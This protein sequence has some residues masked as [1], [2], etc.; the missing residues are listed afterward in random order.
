MLTA[1]V[2]FLFLLATIIEL[3]TVLKNAEKKVKIIH[4]SMMLI[5]FCVLMLYSLDITVPSPSGVI[6]S[7]IEAVFKLKG[8]S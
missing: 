5:S 8:S 6:V 7:V 2:L 3:M 1:I 4:L